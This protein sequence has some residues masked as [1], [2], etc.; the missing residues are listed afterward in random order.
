MPK[1]SIQLRTLTHNLS[2]IKQHAPKQRIL[3]AVKANAYGH[4]AT[5]TARHLEKAGVT[6]FGVATAEEALELRGAGIKADI[7]I[8]SPVY[9]N[10]AE[11]ADYNIGLTVVDDASLEVIRRANVPTRVHLKV[12]TGMGR[13]GLSWRDAASLARRID[14]HKHLCL[15]S[16]WTHFAA[17]D[18]EDKTYTHEQLES[19]NAFLRDL[20]QHGIDVPLVHAANSAAIFAHPDAHFDMVRPGIALYGY[21]SSG[22]IASLAPELTPALTLSAPITFI[23][24]VKAGQFVS[25]SN[26]WQAPHDTRVAT[27]RIGYA[28][29][30]PRLLTG[31]LD[32][33]IHQQVRSVIGRICMDQ[34]MIDLAD[35]PASVGD[36]VTIFGP[37]DL[38]AET[39]AARIGTISYELLTSLSPRVEREYV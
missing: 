19:F 18:N 12:D 5:K 33:M 10:I 9:Q 31:K 8:F 21:H 24:D 17:S 30:L 34:L 36:R 20:K 37:G 27:V 11:L 13:L 28:D 15:S 16:V 38:N 25:Y 35:T 39:L 7:L 32:V 4:G 3:A 22:F 6:Y 1:A 29:G 23:K 14:T 2:V 26:L